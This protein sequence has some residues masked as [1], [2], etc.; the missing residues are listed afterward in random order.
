MFDIIWQ[1][2]RSRARIGQLKLNNGIV[3]TPVFMPVG[4]KG[5]VK[6]LSVDELDDLGTQII[7]SNTYHLNHRPGLDVIGKHKGLH[8]FM[9][10]E[11]PILTDSG[12]YQVFSLSKHIKLSDEGVE[13][14]YPQTGE[15]TFFTPEKVI[16]TQ[17]ALGSDI[18]MVFDQPV[19]YPAKRS[20]A[21]EA[22]ERTTKWAAISKKQPLNRGQK[23]F[24]IMQGAFHKDLRERS[25][26]ELIELDFDGYAI[27]G[28]SVGEPREVFFEVLD[29]ST[30]MMPEEK[31]R[32]LMGVGDPLG[33]IKGIQ[34]GADMFDS[35]LPT[36]L[37][38]NGSIF[39]S[40]GRLNLK[41]AV[42]RL[43]TSALDK[44]CQCSVCKKYTRSYLR[45]LYM[46][47]EILAHRLLSWHNLFYVADLVNKAKI[48]L[49]EGNIKVLEKELKGIYE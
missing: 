46:S 27:G 22:L 21:I 14:R 42:Y 39:T 1:D 36:R 37:A 44:Q 31:P 49:K 35:V 12:G 7:L 10:W 13:F 43:D 32:Y 47:Q 5:A 9:R 29:Y 3:E 17:R 16:E 18:V 11:K 33:L 34:M 4:T 6:T 30:Q 28:L 20:D 25:A 8:R 15:L 2:T 19:G 40:E 24:G 26:A 23:M 45:H 41:N 48:L 38:R